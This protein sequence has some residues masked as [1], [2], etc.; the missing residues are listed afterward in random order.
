MAASR[1]FSGWSLLMI[2]MTLSTAGPDPPDDPCMVKAFIADNRT[3]G[4]LSSIAATSAAVAL[5]T[6][7]VPKSVAAS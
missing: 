2:A 6:L 5:G 1:I 4:S 7:V 3:P